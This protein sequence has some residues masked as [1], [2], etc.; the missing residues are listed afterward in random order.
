[1]DTLVVYESKSGC[2][3]DCAEKIAKILKGHTRVAALKQAVKEDLKSYDTIVVGSPVYAGKIQKDI[4]SFC[5]NYKDVLMQKKLGLFLC[6]ATPVNEPGFL[7]KFFAPDLYKH[8]VSK[9]NL[10]GEYRLDKMNI[11]TRKMI[12]MLL[13][14]GKAEAPHVDENEI[15]KFAE[16]MNN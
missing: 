6:S 13:K 4:V 8:A 14:S 7:E 2:T 3:K 9:R 1:M 11:M 12:Q 10:G 5:N 15:K 16:E